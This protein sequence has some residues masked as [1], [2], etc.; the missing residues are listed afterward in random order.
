MVRVSFATRSADLSRAGDRTGAEV[1]QC[2]LLEAALI[3]GL[4]TNEEWACFESFM[5]EAGSSGGRPRATTGGT[6]TLWRDL[7]LEFGNWNSVHRQFR[8]WTASG[9][10][11]LLLQALADGSG[12]ADLLQMIDS[13]IIRAHHCAAGARGGTMGQCLGRSCGGPL[14]KGPPSGQRP[15]PP[16]WGCADVR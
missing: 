5:V 1:V 11:D 4:L 2:R 3:R 8:R 9:L 16:N 6:S 14:D 7:P 15:R 13:T 10:W 12:N